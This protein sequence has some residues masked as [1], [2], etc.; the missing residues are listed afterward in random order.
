MASK[1]VIREAISITQKR[2]CGLTPKFC[3]ERIMIKWQ[4][5]KR[6]ANSDRPLVSSNAKLDRR[7]DAPFITSALLARSVR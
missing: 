3:C 2:V 6:A 4:R 1:A 7:R 5:A